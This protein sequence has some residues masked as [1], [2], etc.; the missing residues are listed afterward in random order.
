MTTTEGWKPT[1]RHYKGGLYRL[2][3]IGREERGLNWV[4]I[5]Q[6]DRGELWTRPVEEF[7]GDIDG[8]D[9]GLTGPRFA[10]VRP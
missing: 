4:A 7:F 10:P 6:N 1:H 8:L 9:I 2:I 5:Y 3:G